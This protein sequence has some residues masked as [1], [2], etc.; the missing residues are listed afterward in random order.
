[1]KGRVI[2]LDSLDGREAAALIEDGRLSDLL[3][4]S[5]LPR[6]GTRSGGD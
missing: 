4:D 3:I 6:P 5:D 1:M 2:A